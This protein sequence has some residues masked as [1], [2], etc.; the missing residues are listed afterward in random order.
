MKLMTPALPL[1]FMFNGLQCSTAHITDQDNERFYQLSH[2][3]TEYSDA[4]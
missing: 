4:E 2:D 1:H 3:Q